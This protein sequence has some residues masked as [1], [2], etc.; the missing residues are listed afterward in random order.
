M[1][2]CAPQLPSMGCFGFVGAPG[3]PARLRVIAAAAAAAASLLLLAGAPVE[4][5]SSSGEVSA[6]AAASGVSLAGS[7]LRNPTVSAVSAVSSGSW[8]APEAAVD[9]KGDEAMYVFKV[10]HAFVVE[11]CSWGVGLLFSGSIGDATSRYCVRLCVCLSLVSLLGCLFTFLRLFF[12]HIQN[13]FEPKLQRMICRIGCTVMFLSLFSSIACLS[14]LL[15]LSPPEEPPHYQLSPSCGAPPA[16]GAPGGDTFLAPVQAPFSK[17]ASLE[18]AEEA[19]GG[20]FVLPWG[21]P[22]RELM[23]AETEEETASVSAAASTGAPQ[24]S[25]FE[26]STQPI[27]NGGLEAP[28]AA[29]SLELPPAAAAATAAAEP[30]AATAA[31]AEYQQGRRRIPYREPYFAQQQLFLELGK[32]LAQSTALYSFSSLMI[33]SCGEER[34]KVSLFSPLGVSFGVSLSLSACNGVKKGLYA[35]LRLCRCLL[36]SFV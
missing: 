18:E 33:N 8:G 4:A 12:S 32:Q 15:E 3:S 19:V 14:V 6:A 7:T 9:S 35:S 24:L 11:V 1:R 29:A 27:I 36:G 16:K 26:V 30:A 28:T 2:S 5:S 10:L 23:S 22:I 25:P 31:A 17:L 13:Y 21:A 34:D 20:P